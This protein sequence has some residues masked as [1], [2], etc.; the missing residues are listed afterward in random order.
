MTKFKLSRVYL[1]LQKNE[2]A[3]VKIRGTS[4]GI[5]T[6]VAAAF[7]VFPWSPDPSGLSRDLDRGSD[8]QTG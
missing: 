8:V 2:S 4:G 6:V 7:S 1:E 5:K 3:K